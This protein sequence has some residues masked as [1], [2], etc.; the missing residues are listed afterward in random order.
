[1][2]DPVGEVQSA[3]EERL[4][5]AFGWTESQR[6]LKQIKPIEFPFDKGSEKLEQI[7]PPGVYFV[8]LVARASGEWMTLD[9]QWAAYCVSDRPTSRARTTGGAGSFG[10]GAYEIAYRTAAALDE[11]FP[12]TIGASTLRVLGIE[13]LTGL[14]LA[15]KRLSVFAVTFAGKIAADFGA[16]AA[17]LAPFLR[18]HSDWE[19]D[20]GAPAPSDP[21]P[22]TDPHATNDVTLTGD[23]P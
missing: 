6:T 15:S 20:P 8:P 4:K 19:L 11:F 10:M 16:P 18:Y 3:I 13:N 17:N 12:D 2:N 9:Q 1:M 21:L 14:T 23:A 7:V 22:I 5:S